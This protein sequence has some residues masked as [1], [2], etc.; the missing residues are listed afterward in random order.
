MP[1]DPSVRIWKT[2]QPQA[3]YPNW[4][5]RYRSPDVF[6]DNDGDRSVAWD[7]SF[8]YY[9]S[10]DEVGEPSKGNSHNRL[11]AVV[12]N[13]GT[14]AANNVQAVISYSPYGVVS[15]T[16]YQHVHFKEIGRVN[17]NLGPAGAS[18]AE[19]EVEFQWDLSDL[20]ENNGGLW[21]APV[22]FFNHF[23]VRAEVAYPGDSN[24]GNNWT[25]HNY[26][27]II[28]SS[29]SPP[30]YIVIAN[31]DDEAK[32]GQLITTAL[33]KN[34]SFRL[35]GLDRSKLPFSTAMWRLKVENSESEKATAKR[36]RP[37]K[38]SKGGAEELAQLG[39]LTL[40]PREERLVTIA[41]ITP[42]G[43]QERQFVEVALKTDGE[44][45][46]GV[47]FT[48]QKEKPRIGLLPRQK[49]LHVPRYVAS[50][51]RPIRF[52]R[53]GTVAKGGED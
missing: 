48:V 31:M 16:L 20:T 30:L 15:G 43:K 35:R 2:T 11:F 47:S 3:G 41:I 1:A 25:Q 12:R 7:G 24:P 45:A 22:A 53:K 39:S 21:P 29:A 52:Y 4:W 17:V 42:A 18:D 40:Q 28:S 34:W 14:S 13:L 38:T 32:E 50:P 44:V 19:K 37:K 27:N 36:E 23:C 9:L 6:V 10:I 26:A 8:K 49:L 51:S 5:P 33:P 46:G